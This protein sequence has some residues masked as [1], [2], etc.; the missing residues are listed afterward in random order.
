MNKKKK[1][2]FVSQY[3]YPENFRGNDVAIHLASK[4]HD[5]HVV[6]G[7][8]NYPHGKFYSGYGFFKKRREV[9]SGVKITRL[10]IIPRGNNKIMLL[11]TL[12]FYRS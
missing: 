9:L 6:C 10:P 3:F 7:T 2:L 12:P 4:G 5:V 8:P 1:I 11:G